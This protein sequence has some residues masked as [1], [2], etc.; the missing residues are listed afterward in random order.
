[1]TQTDSTRFIEEGQAFAD[2]AARESKGVRVRTPQARREARSVVV[3]G[4]GQ[5]GLSVGYHLKRLGVDFVI[6][7][8]CKRTGD[9]WRQR[10]NSLRLFTS[11][12]FDAL[13]GM[14]FPAARNA[15][16]TKDDMADYLEA[17][18]HRFSLPVRHDARVT[19]LSREGERYLVE[20]PGFA[21]V[22][23][24]VVVAMATYQE[25]RVPAFARE[26][27]SSI[28]QLHSSD[29]RA[30]EQ[31]APGPVLV[32]GA[33]NSGAELA[34]EFRARGHEV[35]LSGRDTGKVP[36]DMT[37]FIAKLLLVRLVLRCLFHYVMTV[38]TPMG[39]K[40]RTKVLSSGGPL[41]RTKRP[42]LEASGVVCVPR[43]VGAR[44]GLPL[45]DDGRVLDV[46]N[47]VW[48]TGFHPGFS[49]LALPVFDAQGEPEH[50][51]GVVPASPGLYFVG[52]HFLYAMS[53]TM[54][55]GVGR[56]AARIARA[57]RARVASAEGFTA[58]SVS[59][60]QA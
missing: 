6:L 23:D 9:V 34:K 21:I 24:Q 48:C 16:P 46:P 31:I 25:R 27:R 41:I 43:T 15:F 53:S 47:V 8:A 4:G 36:F 42:E 12:K 33:G 59:P 44:D 56:D 55:H 28:V 2:L 58:E 3:I 7:D 57:V 20:G 49:W 11:S 45:L 1:M 38:K 54:I 30:P 18:V 51:C 13:D 40:M 22:A 39:R 14:S 52:L 50:D 5:A 10:W 26:L 37:S 17:Y 60:Q 29:Y 32:V 35:L 19:R